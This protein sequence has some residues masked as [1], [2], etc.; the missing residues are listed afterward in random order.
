CLSRQGVQRSSARIIYPTKGCSIMVDQTALRP[1]VAP[2]PALRLMQVIEG[3]MP[4]RS[5]HVAAQLAIADHLKDGPRTVAALAALTRTAAAS[6]HRLLRALAQIGIFVEIEAGCF[7]N[8]ELS[9]YLRSDV[10][11]S[12]QAFARMATE[13][14]WRCWGELSYSIRTGKPAFDSLYGM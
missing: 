10:P 14:P 2:A 1:V 9:T 13:W 12:L 8:T 7:A 3:F 6:L 11:G 5:V 4:A